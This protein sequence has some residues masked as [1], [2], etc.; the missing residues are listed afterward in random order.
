MTFTYWVCGA[1][2]PA[3]ACYGLKVSNVGA[4]CFL[5]EKRQR[6]DLFGRSFG[7]EAGCTGWV[8]WWG[9]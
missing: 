5:N 7:P 2:V 4:A 3:K 1:I 9:S 6:L 8:G